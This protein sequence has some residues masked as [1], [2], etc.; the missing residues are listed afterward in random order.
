MFP[1]ASE[2]PLR[3]DL[4][5]DTLEGIRAFDPVSQRSEKKLDSFALLPVSEILLSEESIARFRQGYRELFGAVR[6]DPLYEAV[7]AGRRHPGME[8]WLP[9][10]WE[11]L[12]TLMDYLPDAAVTMDA[13][14]EDACAA[15]FDTIADYYAA[16]LAAGQALR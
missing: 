4:F 12:E 6:E 14:G 5:G 8:H 7:S 1:P 16:R 9:L 2:E 10:F 15:R 13:N 3:L 11:R